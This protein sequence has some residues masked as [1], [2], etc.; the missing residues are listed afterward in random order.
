[1]NGWRGTFVLVTVTLSIVALTV[2]VILQIFVLN[3]KADRNRMEI[4]GVGTVVRRV[5]CAQAATTANATRIRLSDPDGEVEGVR[6]FLTRMLAQRY[7][8]RLSKGLNC[9]SAPG[10]PPFE[11][12]VRRALREIREILAQYP[13]VLKVPVSTEATSPRRGDATRELFPEGVI[14]SPVTPI[15][16][17]VIGISPDA[18][19]AGGPAPRPT[20]LPQSS[21]PPSSPAPA[22]SGEAPEGPPR[23]LPEVAS[24]AAKEAVE[25]VGRGVE[26][27]VPIRP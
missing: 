25:G 2:A 17:Q 3:P 12:Q 6:H 24:D 10:F 7:T 26:E 16:P 9:A 23:G 20:P 5:I 18:P 21:P 13:A 11:V 14:P 15:N 1:M 4:I 22:P 27:V 19:V 8:L